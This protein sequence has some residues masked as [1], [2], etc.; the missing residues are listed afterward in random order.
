MQEDYRL[1]FGVSTACE[2]DVEAV[3]SEEKVASFV[4]LS[5]KKSAFFDND[6]VTSG[7]P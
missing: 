4:E 2:S 1:D 3:C 5:S 7:K 6:T